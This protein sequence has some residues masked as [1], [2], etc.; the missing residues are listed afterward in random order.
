MKDSNGKLI[1]NEDPQF[2]C[3]VVQTNTLSGRPGWWTNSTPFHIAAAAT[4]VYH[5]ALKEEFTSTV[6]RLLNEAN[7]EFN[8]LDASRK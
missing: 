1:S 8:L 7:P 2:R 5:A 3:K 4:G 6:E